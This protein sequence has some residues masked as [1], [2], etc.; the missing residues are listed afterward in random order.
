M[1][2]LFLGTGGYH[3]N[4]RRHTAGILIPELGVMFDAGTCAFRAPPR[5]FSNEL[6]IFL[7][8]P[9]LD[10]IIG[11]TYLLVPLS[12]KQIDKC[13]IHASPT[14]IDAVR[15]HLF[16]QPLFPVLPPFDFLPL[17]QQVDV[18]GGRGTLTHHPLQHPGGSL[19]FVL[20]VDG[21]RIAYITDTTV[22]G[23]YTDFIR[24][25]DL[26]IHECYF[27]DSLSEWAAKTGHSHTSPVAMLA[28]DAGVKR[29]Y[30]THIDP[31][32]SDDDPI[33]IA[34]ARAIFPETY[35]AE[36]LLEVDV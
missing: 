12:L 27:P 22:D 31:Q 30:L 35:V 23:S 28:R 18:A 15:Q 13:R 9:H 1:R 6:D 19:G 3:P 36:D 26:L 2:L 33:D 34:A 21:K 5:L 32:R 7:T 24:G 8:H 16:S 14:T 29:M 25:A 10:H 4:E 20:E 17:A 11:L